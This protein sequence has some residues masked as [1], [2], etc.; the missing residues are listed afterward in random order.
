MNLDKKPVLKKNHQ[1]ANND[2]MRILIEL[3][4]LLV[5]PDITSKS[6]ITYV[7][8]NHIDPNTY[9][10]AI[11]GN[12][13]MPLIYFCCS[14]TNLSDFFEY[15]IEKKVNLMAPMICDDPLR[16]IELLYYSQV[17]YIPILIENGCKLDPNMVPI[18]GEKFLL[19]GNITKLIT[20]YKHNA[21]TKED[22]LKI[23]Q[24]P[25]LLFRVL[26]RLYERIF[27]LCKQ[28]KDNAKLQKLIDEIMKNYLNVFKLF[29]K[30]GANINQI[31][32]DE[33]FLQRTLNTYFV[34][35]IKLAILYQP[36]FDHADLL[37]YSNFDQSNRHIMKIIYNEK[38]Y[39]EIQNLLKD[40]VIP[41]KINVKK[42]VIKK[43]I[44][45]TKN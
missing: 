42:P 40:K 32:N 8:Q 26:D 17:Q 45:T 15:L 41:Q 21:V 20:L 11:H 22:L 44:Q 3:L 31:E 37:H 39:I 16:Q 7:E 36:N 30:N 19:M 13:Q 2:P 29:F 9:L 38:N 5:N 6:L 12:I 23:T 34:D 43:K 35:L 33:T 18:N 10:P 14:N 1:K 4:K 28:I 27:N 24:K 25:G